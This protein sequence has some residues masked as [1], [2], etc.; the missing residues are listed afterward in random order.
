M[1]NQISNILEENK[2]HLTKLSQMGCDSRNSATLLWVGKKKS[3]YI[4]VEKGDGAC[5]WFGFLL[6]CPSVIREWF[7]PRSQ[8]FSFTFFSSLEKGLGHGEGR[9]ESVNSIFFFLMFLRVMGG[10]PLELIYVAFR[11]RYHVVHL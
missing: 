6:E 1:P 11:N 7:A 2:K 5:L 3:G 4:A 10:H 8:N 9:F